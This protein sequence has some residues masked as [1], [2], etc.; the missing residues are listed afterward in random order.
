[1][2]Q[3]PHVLDNWHLSQSLYVPGGSPYDNPTP[4]LQSPS[5]N[6]DPGFLWYPMPSNPLDRIIIQPPQA[7][8]FFTGGQLAAYQAANELLGLG[9]GDTPDFRG[10]YLNVASDA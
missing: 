4:V 2:P 6:P 8:P 10:Q 1:M 7:F 5:S 3:S 9:Q